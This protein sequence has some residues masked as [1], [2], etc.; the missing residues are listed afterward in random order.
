MNRVRGVQYRNRPPR[1]AP[2]ACP[3]RPERPDSTAAGVASSRPPRAL[4]S[5][6]LAAADAE[7]GDEFHAF[8]Q[9]EQAGGGGAVEDADSSRRRRHRRAASQRFCTARQVLN[10]SVSASGRGPGRTGV[11][12]AVA[13]HG[14]VQRRPRIL[15]ASIAHTVPCGCSIRSS[16]ARERCAPRTAF[17]P[18]HA[19][20]SDD[21]EVPAACSPPTRRCA[22]DRMRRSTS[23]G[24]GSDET[25]GC[26]GARM[27]R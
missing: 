2:T 13:R 20:I 6:E 5:A 14:Q 17:S 9:V 15:P 8:G 25:D 27:T 11:A 10:R 3:T 4:A 26:R 24:T 23:S 16:P 7:V 12:A 22:I 1:T 18:A 19:A 21:D